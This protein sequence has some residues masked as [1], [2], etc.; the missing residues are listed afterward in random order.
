MHYEHSRRK[1]TYIA[2]GTRVYLARA[3]FVVEKKQLGMFWAAAPP[4]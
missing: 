1:T 2:G 3:P 4:H